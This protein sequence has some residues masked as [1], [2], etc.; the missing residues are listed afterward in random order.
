MSDPVQ[1]FEHTS[2]PVG[3]RFTDAR[4]NRLVQYNE[5]HGNQFF[6]VGHNR[7]HF[8]SYVGVIQ[9]GNL[10]IE[11]LPKADKSPESPAQKQKWQSALVEMLRQSGFIRLATI[12]D[13]DC[14]CARLPCWRSSSSP[15]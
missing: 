10:T 9:V 5:R 1:V 4:F 13:A 12:S 7:I 6:D 14:G 8:R 11:I 2:L 3:D 15:S